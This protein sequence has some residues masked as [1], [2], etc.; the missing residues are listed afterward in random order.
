MT[1]AAESIAN[2]KM[3]LNEA[4]NDEIVIVNRQMLRAFKKVVK[5]ARKHVNVLIEDAN[6][7]Q[8]K[9]PVISDEQFKSELRGVLPKIRDNIIEFLKKWAIR[10]IK[11]LIKAIPRIILEPIALLLKNL[12]GGMSLIGALGFALP[13]VT[14][15]AVVGVGGA[16]GATLATIALAGA[17]LTSGAGILASVIG[18]ITSVFAGL[19]SAIIIARIGFAIIEFSFSLIEIFTDIY[20][21]FSYEINSELD[22]KIYVMV[23]KAVDNA[24]SKLL[25]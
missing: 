22:N 25:D 11:F 8:T 15:G 10:G 21:E 6:T 1:T 16:V 2:T 7:A 18:A 20:G 24:F 17:A 3:L 19:V 5:E 13:V 23:D 14:I 9:P 12:I 4:L